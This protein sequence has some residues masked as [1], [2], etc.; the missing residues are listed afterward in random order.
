[1][2]STMPDIGKNYATTEM[3]STMYDSERNRLN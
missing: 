1:M 3:T 2:N